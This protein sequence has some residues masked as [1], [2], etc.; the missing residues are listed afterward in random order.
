MKQTS[1]ALPTP[2]EEPNC[3]ADEH[4]SAFLNGGVY[5]VY[6]CLAGKMDSEPPPPGQIQIHSVESDSVSLSWGSPAGIEGIPQ[7]FQITVCSADKSHQDTITAP[8]NST[9]ISNLRPARKYSFTITTVLENGTQSKPVST[10]ASTKTHLDILSKLG[11]EYCLPGK[12]TLSRV[13]AI[14]TESIT[15]EPI[16]SVKQLPWRFMKRLMMVNVTA[17][18]I[19]CSA[20]ETDTNSTLQNFDVFEI[21][22]STAD[23]NRNV[24]NPLDLVTALFLCSDSF[25]QQEMMLKMSMCQFAVPLLLPD[26]RSNQCTL[27]L[28][29]MRDIVK[30]FRPHSLTDS[31]GF[32]EGSIISTAMPMVSFVRLGECSLSKSQILNKMKTALN[33][34]MQRK[35]LKKIT[36]GIQNVV[37]F[38][39]KQLPLH[40]KLWKDL[41]KIEKEECRLRKAGDQPIET[42]KST[43]KTDKQKLR[44]QQINSDTSEAMLCFITAISNESKEQRSYFLKWLRIKLDA[45]ARTEL[46]VLRDEY[47][48][49]CCNISEN[50]ERIAVLDEQISNSSLGIEHFMREMGQLYEAV[51]SFPDSNKSRQQFQHLPRLGADLLLD[52]FPLE[53]VDGDASNIPVRWVTDII[54][55]LHGKLKKKSRVLVVTVLGV[56]S[57]GKSTLLKTMFGVQFA[58]SSGRCTRG[59]FM[60]LIRVK[61]DL[62]DELKC[63]FILVIDTEGLKSTELAQLEDSYEHDNEL[64]TL[65][66][67]LSDVT[68]INIAMENSTEMKDILQIVVHAFL[69]MKEVGKKPKCQFVHQNVGDVSAHDKNTRDRKMLLEQLNKM[70][71]AAAKMEKQGTDKKFTD[72][73]EYDP[74]RNNWYIPGLWHGNPPMAPVNTGYSETVYDF[75]KSLIE[76]LKSCKDQKPAGDIKEFLEW[77]TS[78]WKAVKF[79]NFIFSFKNSLVAEAYSTL[80]VEY[81]TWEWSFQKHMYQWLATAETRISNAT[82]Q[83]LNLDELLSTLKSEALTEMMIQ[84]VETLEKLL[85]YYDRKEGH[86]NLVESYRA[87]FENSIKTLRIE[88]ENSLTYKLTAAIDFQKGMKEVHDVNE[89]HKAILEKR[90]LQLLEQCRERKESL[91]QEQLKNKFEKMWTKTESTLKFKGLG[92]RDIVLNVFSQL[93]AQLNRYGSSVNMILNEI[94]DLTKCGETQFTV[95]EEHF[96]RVWYNKY[97]TDVFHKGHLKKAKELVKSVI[98]QC[99]EFV[100]QKTN[101]K[102]D[103]HETYTRELLEMIDEKLELKD[104][105]NTNAVFEVDLKLHIG[106]FAAREF[107]KMHTNFTEVNDPL[108]QLEKSKPQYCTDFIDL[109]HKKDQSLKKAKEFTERCLKPAVRE[110]SQGG[111]I[112]KKLDSLPFKPQDE[113]FK[114]VF[115]CGKQCPFCMVPCKA[116]GKDH[117]HLRLP[118]LTFDQ[119]LSCGLDQHALFT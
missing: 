5:W 12:I 98:K 39:E 1:S 35:A 19:K 90:V 114:R 48:E 59:A 40:R 67:G 83:T 17:R 71:Q 41:S 6:I 52:G 110:Y 2:A 102:D 54:T 44:Q 93:R 115:G 89:K 69:R 94:K 51:S 11:L 53:L 24:I 109:Y 38:K 58:V 21:M 3:E 106:G 13:L 99:Q 84:E 25:L 8:S 23:Q 33:V 46:S 118:P 79:E 36:A 116:G 96:D 111:D 107:Q 88:I 112:K 87:T 26:C 62:Q 82:N 113:L 104:I 108:K 45:T 74:E 105:K 61:E 7:S 4:P 15:D 117:K 10:T 56:Q 50:M 60:L 77:V 57:T 18:S 103:Y 95:T 63:D 119:I 55:E 78:L 85:K 32:E 9:V 100:S 29:A 47:K 70:T 30:K 22:G 97:I 20:A 76:V 81:H 92:Q 68:I 73:M 49:K 42:Y 65:V 34:G 80:C 31:K 43:L 86:V 72:I 101:S 64:A 37:Q 27:M 91:S 28:W 75:K 66:V 14:G 16:Q